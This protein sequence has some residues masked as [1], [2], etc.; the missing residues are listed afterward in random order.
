MIGETWK[1]KPP[2]GLARNKAMSDDV[3]WQG[4]LVWKIEES[5]ESDYQAS[6]K[7]AQNPDGG[8]VPCVCE[9]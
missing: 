5:I 2:F 1:N 4:V 7:T 9:R 8:A 3:A 6:L